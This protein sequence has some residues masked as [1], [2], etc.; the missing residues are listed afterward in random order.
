MRQP[1][2]PECCSRC[3]AKEASKSW[4]IASQ[5]R[6]RFKDQTN[7]ELVTTYWVRVPLCAA[8]HRHLTMVWY[9]FWVV[10]VMAGLVACGLLAQYFSDLDSVKKGL[11]A[12]DIGLVIGV[13]IV[14]VGIIAAVVAW[15]L[16]MVFVDCPLATYDPLSGR[17]SFGNK[18]YQQLYDR[19]NQ[20]L[21]TS[22]NPLGI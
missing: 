13:S 16:H 1:R 10:G 12:F 21:N 4:T 7:V 14:V 18:Q 20:F 5:T 6:D 19:A 2:L 15:V 3:L 9:L 8:C 22:R 17:L 11:D